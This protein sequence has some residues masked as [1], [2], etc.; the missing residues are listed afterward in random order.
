MN[1]SLLAAI[2]SIWK[3][4]I[5]LLQRMND[6]IGNFG[7]TV[8]VFSIMLR[9][10]L[11]PL[12]VWQKLI[13]RKQ[14]AKM[15][16]LRPQLEKIQKQ[17]ANRPDLLKQKQYELQ[18]GSMSIFTSCL[19]MIVTLV[20]F[21]VVFQ[22]FRQYIV[23]YNQEQLIK[24]Y[25]VYVEFFKN[26]EYVDQILAAYNTGLPADKII[27]TY[28]D[29]NTATGFIDGFMPSYSYIRD[30]GLIDELNKTLV[31]KYP[32]ESWLWVKNVFM[33]DTWANVI[34]SVEN[35]TST[36]FGGVGATVPDAIG[37]S[38]SYE[39]LMNPIMDSYNKKSFWDI[40]HWNGYLIL[41]I[42]SIGTSFLSTT[43]QQ[44]MQPTQVTGDEA[45][46][47]QQR[48]MNKT[49]TYMMPLIL[50]IFAIMY[51]AAFAIYYFVSNFMTMSTSLIFNLII[52]KV[53]KKK[54]NQPII[55]QKNPAAKPNK[56]SN[57]AKR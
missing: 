32:I 46:Q 16:A 19:P 31:A 25:N 15:D 27:S 47:K 48:I 13:M 17:Y 9:L 21:Y 50:G 1:F 42:L 7:W 20:I 35:F 54:E 11:L 24:L 45:Q 40:K 38:V 33:S 6:G 5:S 39:Q 34:P 53:D 41:P 56:K 14:K 55:I 52:K 12:D 26:P 44:K 18:K 23:Q 8:V 22:G 43:L 49:M 51:S 57:K 2:S 3:P 29:P 37:I 28:L 30:A 36:R 4:I 10:L